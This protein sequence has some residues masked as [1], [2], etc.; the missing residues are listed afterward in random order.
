[1]ADIKNC[2]NARGRIYT[3][4]PGDGM[5]IK[6]EEVSIPTQL[7]LGLAAPILDWHTDPEEDMLV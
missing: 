5:W 4:T 6:V 3:L 7:H 2:R 1:M